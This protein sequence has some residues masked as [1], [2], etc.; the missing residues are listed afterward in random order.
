MTI[1][2][3]STNKFDKEF[4]LMLK[5]GKNR[6]KLDEFIGLIEDGLNSCI[7]H[8]LILPD[9]YRLHKLSGNYQ[10]LWECHLEP[11]WLIVFDLNDHTL[12]L[13]NTGSHSDLFKK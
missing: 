3:L 2:I 13:E 11:D 5:R 12:I 10:N 6:K 1:K 7:E 8:Y 4:K 9:K